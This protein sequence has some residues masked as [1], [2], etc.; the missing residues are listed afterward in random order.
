MRCFLTL[1]W[2]KWFAKLFLEA[3]VFITKPTTGNAQATVPPCRSQGLENGQSLAKRGIQH[4]SCAIST[5]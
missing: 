2:A 3:H 1:K 4:K 5:M